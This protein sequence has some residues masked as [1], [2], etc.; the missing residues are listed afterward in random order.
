VRYFVENGD[1]SDF[2][3]DNTSYSG[4]CEGCHTASGPFGSPET[5]WFRRE[6]ADAETLSDFHD[7]AQKPEP[8][9]TCH[10]HSAGFSCNGCHGDCSTVPAPGIISGT[11]NYVSAGPGGINIKSWYVE[12]NSIPVGEVTCASINHSNSHVEHIINGHLNCTNCHYDTITD[13]GAYHFNGSINLTIEDDVYNFQYDFRNTK[14]RCFES[15]HGKFDKTDPIEAAAAVQ[16]GGNDPLPPDRGSGCL[17]CHGATEDYVPRPVETA[18]SFPNKIDAFQYAIVG[19]GATGTYNSGN[20]GAGYYDT[21]GGGTLPGCISTQNPTDDP[22]NASPIDGCH[23]RDAKHFPIKSDTDPYRLGTA[24]VSNVDGLC[25]YC[26]MYDASG[27]AIPAKTHTKTTTGSKLTWGYSWDDT[28]NPPKCVDCHDPHGD[29]NDY[30][31]KNEISRDFGSTDYGS[32]STGGNAPNDYKTAGYDPALMIPAVFNLI[33]GGQA[34]DYYSLVSDGLDDGI[35]QVCHTQ[36]LVYNNIEHYEGLS[37]ELKQHSNNLDDTDLIED[38]LTDTGR[39]CTECHYHKDG[40]K[41][42]SI[43]KAD[44]PVDKTGA[45]CTDCHLWNPDGDPDHPLMVLWDNLTNGQPNGALGGRQAQQNGDENDDNDDIDNYVFSEQPPPVGEDPV[46]ANYTDRTMV[47]GFQWANGGHGVPSTQSLLR[48]SAYTAKPGPQLGCTGTVEGSVGDY[49]AVGGCHD[50]DVNH[51]DIINDNPFRLLTVD[52]GGGLS[53]DPTDLCVSCHKDMTEPILHADF[54][55]ST[56]YEE[57]K[58]VDCHDPHGDTSRE[59]GSLTNIN[60]DKSEMVSGT[61]NAAMMQREVVFEDRWTSVDPYG[62]ATG[63]LYPPVRFYAANIDQSDTAKHNFTYSGICEACHTADGSGGGAETQWFRRENADNEALPDFHDSAQKANPCVA[64]HSHK[65]GFTCGGC[66]GFPPDPYD[67]IN[68][69]PIHRHV[70]EEGFWCT[71]CHNGNMTKPHPDNTVDLPEVAIEIYQNV[72]IWF[73]EDFLFNG[74]TTMLNGEEQTPIMSNVLYDDGSSGPD[75][76]VRK[77]SLYTHSSPVTCRNGCHNP[78]VM[79]PVT[80]APNLDKTVIWDDP[81]Q[82]IVC[83][84]CHPVHEVMINQG[85]WT[86]EQYPQGV[87]FMSS[88]LIDTAIKDDCEKCHDQTEHQ[89]GV[90]K[91]KEFGTA[92]I[93]TFNPDDPMSIEPF[94]LGCHSG[95]ESAQPFDSNPNGPPDI[96]KFGTWANSKHKLGGTPVSAGQPRTITLT[97]FGTK[98]FDPLFPDPDLTVYGCHQNA[99]GSAKKKLLIDSLEEPFL[100]EG[101]DSEKEGFCYNCHGNVEGFEQLY[102]SPNSGVKSPHKWDDG[103]S[104]VI[105]GFIGSSSC[106]ECHNPH[107]QGES[108]ADYIMWQNRG[109]QG[110]TGITTDPVD[111]GSPLTLTEKLCFDCHDDNA[112]VLDGLGDLDSLMSDDIDFSNPASEAVS[113]HT[114]LGTFYSPVCT[115]CHPHDRGFSPCTCH[116]LPPEDPGHYVHVVKYE[117]SECYT[118]HYKYNDPTVNTDGHPSQQWKDTQVKSPFINFPPENA[119]TEPVDELKEPYWFPGGTRISNNTGD[120]VP[121]PA[122]ANRLPDENVECYVGCHN[123][124]ISVAERSTG[125]SLPKN[126]VNVAYWDDAGTGALTCVQCHDDIGTKFGLSAGAGSSHPVDVNVSDD[127]YECHDS[128]I[129][130][131]EK[132]D[133]GGGEYAYHTNYNATKDTPMAWPQNTNV[134]LLTNGYIEYLPLTIN[135]VTTDISYSVED[136]P[137][138]NDI[139][140]A[141]CISCH[142]GRYS[143]CADQVFSLGGFAP[144]ITRWYHWE[145]SSHYTGGD[146]GVG[147]SCLG[148]PDMAYTGLLGCHGSAHG[149]EKRNL[150]GPATEIAGANNYNEEEGFCYK[151]HNNT[152]GIINRSLSGVKNKNGLCGPDPAYLMYDDIQQAFGYGEHHPVSDADQ[153]ARGV[154]SEVECTSCHAVHWAN[155][156]WIE[157]PNGKTPLSRVTQLEYAKTCEGQFSLDLLWG[158]DPGEKASDYAANYG[159]IGPEPHLFE[160]DGYCCDGQRDEPGEYFLP[161]AWW[162]ETNQIPDMVTPC[163]DCHKTTSRV[164]SFYVIGWSGDPHGGGSAGRPAAGGD[165]YKWWGGDADH[166]AGC[167]RDAGTSAHFIRTNANYYIRHSARERNM[168][169]NFIMMCT[170]CHD[171]HGGGASLFRDDVNNTLSDDCVNRGLSPTGAP[172][173][174][175]LCGQCHWYY[176]EHHAG[177]SCGNASCHEVNSLHKIKKGGSGGN[178][179]M[180]IPLDGSDCSYPPSA[181]TPVNGL[182]L[183]WTFDEGSGTA[184]NNAAVENPVSDCTYCG[185]AGAFNLNGHLTHSPTYV[186]WGPGVY[187]TPGLFFKPNT[188][189]EGIA[190]LNYYTDSSDG[191]PVKW[192]P[193]QNLQN[194]TEFT[195]EAW[196]NPSAIACEDRVIE[197]NLNVKLRRDI[198]STQFWIKNWGLAIMRYSNDGNPIYGDCTTEGADHDVLRFWVAVG[199]PNNMVYDYWCGTWPQSMIP[200]DKPSYTQTKRNIYDCVDGVPVNTGVKEWVYSFAQTETKYALDQGLIPPE[201]KVLVSDGDYYDSSIGTWQHIVCTWDGQYL[202][203][204]IDGVEAASTDMGGTGDYVM[205]PDPLFWGGVGVDRHIS[206]YF[207]VGG[208]V[209]W[210]TADVNPANG[211]AD[212][213]DYWNINHDYE[214]VV[215]WTSYVGGVDEVKYW[216]RAL[217]LPEIQCKGCHDYPDVTSGAHLV[218]FADNSDPDYKYGPGDQFDAGGGSYVNNCENC[219]GPGANIGNHTGHDRQNFG[220]D[221]VFYDDIL[222]VTTLLGPADAGLTD[223]SYGTRACDKCHGIDETLDTQDWRLQVRNNWNNDRDFWINDLPGGSNESMICRAARTI[224]AERATA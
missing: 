27:V 177:M 127:C 213:A 40:F 77:S 56:M 88:H 28:A 62:D 33:T 98:E 31:V 46:L 25:E 172:N 97:C 45:L 53:T 26:H 144:N 147:V 57:G 183:H 208:R 223:P 120:P 206:S 42:P 170:D 219:H 151:C 94:C 156:K 20:S 195:V 131:M 101:I 191:Y 173:W 142:D 106:M 100:L 16:W 61:V 18:D 207:G 162:A 214:N 80:K 212:G 154:P 140:E 60:D 102:S 198:V 118:C 67:P 38:F 116:D 215:G 220:R 112:P 83:I 121:A 175:S 58:C 126:N 203:I 217:S 187:S 224:I 108:E 51:G 125:T 73:D 222:G 123:P 148:T 174:N 185:G 160:P 119:R 146:I 43:D 22:T 135:E 29:D 34:G 190:Q 188:T 194:E 32:P 65:I 196:I 41:V 124:I 78:I 163:L 15:C 85:T 91:L 113:K 86:D 136:D 39:R 122:T 71:S 109:G 48:T 189:N 216:N 149:S 12:Y 49:Y 105:N 211:I 182:V 95:N 82:P 143:D 130:P 193:V 168:G 89:Q 10:T 6:D 103:D 3:K 59:N 134:P 169:I 114:D 76:I 92:N 96:D 199:D 50:E 115:N 210:S 52:V 209:A 180:G 75:P 192:G 141:F 54:T 110:I 184:I 66:H 68:P 21:S 171:G 55:A 159:G 74:D 35:C 145:G 90:I 14:K 11:P 178:Y 153:A 158:D 81:L 30:M 161:K 133:L 137:T 2:F 164:N 13:M 176:G 200:V 204:N 37:E 63:K 218:H 8:C 128:L 139:M 79:Y 69:S 19:H 9:I 72:D 104:S 132:I 17:F 117:F 186:D 152:S 4:I 181:R 64:C 129:Y 107:Y 44:Y 36:N 47:D 157:T 87:T 167:D 7:P 155:G 1:Q 70:T 23:F 179:D 99:H 150:L 205:I 201:T 138:D 111:G 93:I 84:D 24:H 5:R 166:P 221:T 165:S 197:G 202:K